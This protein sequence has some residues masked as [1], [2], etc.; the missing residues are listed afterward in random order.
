MKFIHMEEMLGQVTNARLLFERWLAFNPD[1]H[2]YRMCIKFELRQNAVERAREVYETYVAKLPG[3]KSYLSYAKFEARIHDV[4]RARAVYERAIELLSDDSAFGETSR[5]L[6]DL[7]V[8]FA[9]F[10]EFHKEV[11]RARAILKFA[12]DHLSASATGSHSD[13]PLYQAYLEFE[14]RNGGRRDVDGAVTNKRALAYEEKVRDDPHDYDAWFDYIRLLEENSAED[15]AEIREEMRFEEEGGASAPSAALATRADELLAPVRDVYERAIANL[16]LKEEKVYWGRYI[17][18]WIRYVLF[19]E[20]M[21]CDVER[22]RQVYKLLL[23]DVIPHRSFTFAKIWIYY[24]QFLIRHDKDLG[25]VRQ[26]LGQALGVCPKPKL[27]K[28]YVNLEYNLGNIDRVRKIYEK[29]LTYD[30][31]DSAVWQSYAEMEAALAETARARAIFEMAVSQPVL[32]QPERVWKA[33]IELE[34]GTVRD[35]VRTR[36]LYERLLEK[37]NHCKVWLSYASF[38]YEPLPP[39]DADEEEDAAAAAARVAADEA[40]DA[41]TSR[42]AKARAVF[43]RGFKSIR[44][45]SPDEKEDAVMVLEAWRNFERQVLDALK[46]AGEAEP[47]TDALAKVD[48]MMP[49]RIKRKRRMADEEGYE[50][51]FDYTFPDEAGGESSNAAA[52]LKLLEAAYRWKKMKQAEAQGGGE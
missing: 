15:L 16:P 25:A 39:P 48:G 6:M 5:D 35:R 42:I 17:Y 23:H 34:R 38:E 45:D 7:Y 33:Y 19:E 27:F 50:E 8:A 11:D 4:A 41:L 37:T 46:E 14:K 31:C 28:F 36:S 24:A 52:G 9:S 29:F 40:A 30:P 49:R 3:A 26:L 21:A 1:H 13:T 47:P 2:G 18:L 51:Y 44:Q 10:E 12:L 20:L 43:E 22:A 32:H